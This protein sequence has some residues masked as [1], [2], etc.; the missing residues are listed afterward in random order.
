[1]SKNIF[2]I[3]SRRIVCILLLVI[4]A[5]QLWALPEPESDSISRFCTLDEVTIVAKKQTGVIPAQS[6]D[7]ERL[8]ELSAHSV[9]DAMRYFSGVQIKDFGGVGGIKTVDIRSMGS[10]HVGV[11]YDGIEV[12]NAQN[13]T[14]DLGKFSL[15]NIEAISLYNGQKTESL[16]SAK[17]FGSAGTIYIRT[18]RPTFEHGKKY[19]VIVGM[20]AGSFG[21]A[22]PSL[23]YEQK[24]SESVSLNMNVEYTY[25]TG[26]YPFTIK[27]HL[28]NGSVAWDTTGYRQNGDVNAFRAEAGLFGYLP[29]G[30]WHIKGYYYQSNKGIPRAI[31]RN[32]WTSSQRQWDRNAFVQGAFQYR[33]GRRWE[34]QI[35]AKYANDKMRYLN[36]DTTLMYIDNTF[37]QQEV[38]ISWANQ[39]ELFDWWNLTLSG[40][41]IYN[42]LSSNMANFVYPIRH[43]ALV[44]AATSFHYKWIQAQASVLG[45]F[46]QDRISNHQSTTNN[47]KPCFTPAVFLSY[48]PLLKEQWF[49]RAFYKQ[50][51]RMPTFN[52]LYYTDVGNIALKPEETKQYDVSLEYSKQFTLHD[53]QGTKIGLHAKVDGY[54][55]QVK[56]KIVA[57]PKGNSQYRWM[58]MNIGYVE[59]RG[60]DVNA[61][62]DFTF[63]LSTTSFPLHLKVSGNYTYQKAQDFTDSNNPITYGG[64]IA[65]IPWH[66][67]SALANLKWNGLSFNYSFIYVGER[68]HNSANILANYEQPWYTHDVALGYLFKI[69]PAKNKVNT[70]FDIDTS[71]E[72]N[73]IFN[74]QYDIILNYPMPGINGKL[75]VKFII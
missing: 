33:V 6:L 70:S 37:L 41:Y 44:A 72:I 48:Q 43:T 19:N 57:I 53:A 28:P 65:Y 22:N 39:V 47:Q 18:R 25:A 20:K 71:L 21:L 14:V 49:I 5:H 69:R 38:Y 30:K 56:N 66:S 7:G 13:G 42:T 75:I 11:F 61:G 36:P 73:N 68:Y 8:Q 74:Q 55:N 46:V 59:I 45:N 24:L 12:G 60:V 35:S 16:Q 29:H 52:D 64:Q 31:I 3:L 58:M 27:K 2:Y 1:M 4:C 17:D 50:I 63:P 34:M 54:F 51:F 32:V 62:L 15:E 10:H 23:L 67:C 40:D 9:A 26:R